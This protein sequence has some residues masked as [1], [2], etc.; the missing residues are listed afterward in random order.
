M[1][2]LKCL[3]VRSELPF[4]SYY[5]STDWKCGVKPWNC[6]RKLSESGIVVPRMGIMMILLNILS[7]LFLLGE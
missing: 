2:L 6:D 1:E 5:A 3:I 4:D 7:V